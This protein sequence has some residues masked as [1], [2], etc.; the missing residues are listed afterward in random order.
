MSTLG[1]I[2]LKIGKLFARIREIHGSYE[3]GAWFFGK[4]IVK[5]KKDEEI[6]R[7]A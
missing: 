3:N 4:K 6:K 7:G 1:F 2:L 5:E